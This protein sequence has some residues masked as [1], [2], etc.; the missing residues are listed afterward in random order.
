M[1][2]LA[3]L[4]PCDLAFGDNPD[5]LCAWCGKALPIRRRRW[6][7]DD[8]GMWWSRHH[9]W[10]TAREAAKK[11]DG[12]ACVI[13]QSPQSLEVNHIVPRRGKGYE[14]GCHHHLDGLETLCHDH[15]L[16]V[17]AIQR[18]W[19]AWDQSARTLH[20]VDGVLLHPSDQRLL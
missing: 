12:W 11:R 5:R 2:D 20:L 6:C 13:C 17:T 18:K 16:D 7:C 4:G 3:G 14:N 19:P 9:A 15:H 10:T 1:G 8:C